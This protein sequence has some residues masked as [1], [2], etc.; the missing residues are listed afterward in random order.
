MAETCSKPALWNVSGGLWCRHRR[1]IR[2]PLLS[3]VLSNNIRVSRGFFVET[4][5]PR[6]RRRGRGPRAPSLPR[7]ARVSNR[8]ANCDG[9]EHPA[10]RGDSRTIPNVCARTRGSPAP[11]GRH[12]TSLMHRRGCAHSHVTL[13]KLVPTAE[14]MKAQS[15]PCACQAADPHPSRS[16]SLRKWKWSPTRARPGCRGTRTPSAQPATAS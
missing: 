5:T 9:S 14:D 11:H 1:V 10:P 7:P 6:F 12:S 13:C 16:V 8:T 15:W 2:L 4:V 3:V